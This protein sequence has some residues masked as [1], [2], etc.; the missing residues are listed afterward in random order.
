[1]PFCFPCVPFAPARRKAG[2]CEGGGGSAQP[3]RRGC[4]FRRAYSQKE[5]PLSLPTAAGSPY[6]LRTVTFLWNVPVFRPAY[7]ALPKRS[8]FSR[9]AAYE[10][11]AEGT[12]KCSFLCVSHRAAYSQKEQPLR[13]PTAASSPYILRTVTFLW[14]VPV[15]RPAYSA[16]PKRSDFSRFAA[17]EGGAEGTAKPRRRGCRMGA[18]DSPPL[19]FTGAAGPARGRWPGGILRRFSSAR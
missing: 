19:P 16:L 17:Y 18:P 13:L 8:D 6:I 2:W 10:G 9:F 3:R 15:F 7:S 11:G 4:P 1:M 12:A 5:R 14:N